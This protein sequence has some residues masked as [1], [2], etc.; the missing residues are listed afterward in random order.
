MVRVD[1]KGW[2][3]TYKTLKSGERREYHYHRVTLRRL[4]G[5]VTKTAETVRMDRSSRHIGTKLPDGTFQPLPPVS[6]YA[7][8]A[9]CHTLGEMPDALF[10]QWSERGG[11]WSNLHDVPIMDISLRVERF[12]IGWDVELFLDDG[13]SKWTIDYEFSRIMGREL[14]GEQLH[15]AVQRARE[16]AGDL[17]TSAT[18]RSPTFSALAKCLP[19]AT[20]KRAGSSYG[21]RRAATRNPEGAI[22]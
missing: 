9:P 6:L 22:R 10:E 12:A 11:L 15:L 7:D 3:T 4:G 5:L 20:G 2:F 1:I 18:I 19:R 13:R 21:T 16:E 14:E 17:I 8:L